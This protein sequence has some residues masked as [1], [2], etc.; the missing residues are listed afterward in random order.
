MIM[1]PR[2]LV[3][4][5]LVNCK[6][7]A[8]LS[9]N[10]SPDLLPWA[11]SE[12]GVEQD[13]TSENLVVVAGDASNRRYFRLE[14]NS[15]SYI[16]AEA[17][18]ATEKNSAFVAVRQILATAGV[19]V[20]E[21]HA[22]DFARGFLLLEDLGDRP[23]YFELSDASVDHHYQEAFGLLRAVAAVDVSGVELP[24]YNNELL[25]EELDR[26][27][28]WFVEALLGHTLSGGELQLFTDL[29]A[30]LL[31]NA[32]EQP[33]VL[34][35]RDFHSRNLMLL[36]KDELAVIDFQDAV[37]GPLT[38]DLVSLLRDCYIRWPADGVR[39][40]ALG[41]LASMQGQGQLLDIEETQFLRWF[42]GMGLQRHLKV[43]GTFA[44]L[45]L[46][47]NKPTYLQDLPLVIQYVDEILARYAPE[48]AAFAEFQAW[49]QQCL[50][51][52]IARQPWSKS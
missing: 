48:Q 2:A 51:P 12:L 49:F 18:P 20:P 52:L 29:S 25:G 28:E 9:L 27:P 13:Q 14:I 33:R 34:V 35:H 38:Y 19:R 23:L 40:W 32:L 5:Y 11:C 42:D 43:L 37:V 15:N 7:E 36:P 44:R 1:H 47:D 22:V 24:V 30:L 39:Q 46:R 45:S 4:E 8:A 50:A 31:D 16:L 6:K 26:F 17:P 21:I 3:R 10:V 41:H